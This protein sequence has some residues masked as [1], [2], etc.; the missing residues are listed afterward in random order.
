MIR[1]S[2]SKTYFCSKLQF[3]VDMA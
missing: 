3:N 2:S 1:R